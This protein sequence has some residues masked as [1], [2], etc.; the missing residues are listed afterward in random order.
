MK[1][2]YRLKVYTLTAF[3]F[4]LF[5]CAFDYI[6]VKIFKGEKQV[7]YPIYHWALGFEKIP[8]Q[9][10]KISAEIIS[11]DNMS[12]KETSLKEF[13]KKNGLHWR[14]TG[15]YKYFW[16]MLSSNKEI[17]LTAKKTLE[18]ELLSQLPCNKL[19]YSLIRL[20][21]NLKTR[22]QSKE[23]IKIMEYKKPSQ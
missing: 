22:K 5:A 19:G 20:K 8:V 2:I 12:L 7:I 16:E 14:Y 3:I 21:K 6:Y 9:I 15:Y 23:L 17:S 1:K 4:I 11:C 10:E 13:I 18:A